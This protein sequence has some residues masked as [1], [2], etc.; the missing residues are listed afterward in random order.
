[1]MHKTVRFF[2]WLFDKLNTLS[3]LPILGIRVWIG[4][5]FWR[6]G[7]TKIADWA[8]TVALFK[9][10]YKVPVI[11]PEIAAFLATSVE[12]SAPIMVILG[13]GARFGALAMLLMTAVIEFTYMHF[14][15]HV[16]W[17]LMLSLIF[18]Q[19]AGK[20]SVDYLIKT[21]G[22]SHFGKESF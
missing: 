15:V 8:G 9:D 14:D 18:F 19:G 5:V 10:E 21:K 13:M 22:L 17:A 2:S 3:F 1:M 11:P 7:K 20:A 4:L 12:L 6:S 16:V